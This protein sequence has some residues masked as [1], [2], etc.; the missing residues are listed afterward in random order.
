M[1]LNEDAIGEVL[2]EWIQSGKIKSEELFIV[3]KEHT[4]LFQLRHFITYSILKG[5]IAT[6]DRESFRRRNFDLDC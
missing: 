3:T 5:V 2:Q 1:Y 6:Y 4:Q